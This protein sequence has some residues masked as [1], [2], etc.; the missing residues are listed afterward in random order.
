VSDFILRVPS[1]KTVMHGGCRDVDVDMVCN[2]LLVVA[3]SVR[4][5]GFSNRSIKMNYML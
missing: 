2:E 5:T 3:W 1:Y 4:V